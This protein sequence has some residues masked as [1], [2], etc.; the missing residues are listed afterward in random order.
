[1]KFKQSFIYIITNRDN[2]VLYTGVTSDL[3]KRIYEH[4]QK[5]V[6]GFTE[7]YNI[8]KLVYY[9]TFNNI[10][11]AIEREKQIKAG[12]RQKKINLIESINKDYHD[13]YDEII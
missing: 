3:K 11:Q 5:A 4:K 9:E 7:K 10:K 6:E 1:M 2:T 12:S 8:N 13:L